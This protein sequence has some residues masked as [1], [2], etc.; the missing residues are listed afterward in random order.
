MDIIKKYALKNAID[1]NGKAVAKAVLPKV[2]GEDPSLKSDIPSL[3]KNIEAVV[4]EVNSMTLDEQIS[5]LKKIAPEL[6]VRERSVQGLPDLPNVGSHV[7]LRLAPYPSGPLQIGNARMAILNDEYAKRYNGKL[8]LFYDDTIGT[9]STTDKLSKGIMPKAYG[10]I[11]QDLKWLGVEWHETYYKSD[12]LE[13]YYDYCEQLIKKGKAYVCTCDANV[14]RSVY[15][16]GKKPCPC[17]S[18]EVEENLYLWDKMLNGAFSEGK[19]VVRLKTG[20]ELADPAVRDHVIMRISFKDHPRV[21]KR[22]CVWPTMEFSWAIDNYLLGVTHVIRGKDLMKED[23]VE[24][25]IFDMFGWKHINYLHFGRFSIAIP[26][27]KLKEMIKRGEIK[28]Y[29]DPRTWNIPSLRRRGIQPEA[30]REYILHF[31]MSLADV[32]GSPEI[33]YGKNRKIIDP[34]AKRYYFVKD[35][36]KLRLHGY[37]V[38]FE[39]KVPLHPEVEFGYKLYKLDR[40][41]TYI[42]VEK[43]DVNKEAR[44]KDLMNVV[45]SDGEAIY[46][47]DDLSVKKIHWVLDDHKVKVKVVM[48]DASVIE[49]YAE[50]YIKDCKVGDI[51]QFERFGFGR[52]DSLD[53]VVVY[54]AHR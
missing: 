10:W 20:M 17:R 29:D 50:S 31:G 11:E 40:G 44:L 36:V 2:L 32:E 23:V 14:W 7:V 22:Y 53:P 13:I 35:P 46:S 28:E 52:V 27:S 5:Q 15:K 21:G 38:P 45:F 54:Y 39:A 24:K 47:Q 4:K 33:L 43:K 16:A 3:M 9:S 42:L 1:H 48:P 30:I 51:I 18:R 19:A 34:I 12:R 6:L 26:K 8:I 37:P 25:Q 41:E 49:G